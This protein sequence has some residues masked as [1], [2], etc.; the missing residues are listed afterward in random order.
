LLFIAAAVAVLA[1]L[2]RVLARR[3]AEAHGPWV[4]EEK[5]QVPVAY[6]IGS[7]AAFWVVERVVAFWA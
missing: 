2:S 4:A 7:V 5:L 1:V 6:V 3:S